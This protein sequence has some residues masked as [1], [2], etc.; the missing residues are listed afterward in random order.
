MTRFSC[1]R[2]WAQ[3]KRIDFIN[4][5][6]VSAFM[7]KEVGAFEANSHLSR[8]LDEVEAGR[9]IRITRHGKRI[10]VSLRRCSRGGRK[11]Y[12][13]CSNIPVVGLVLKPVPA[14]AKLYRLAAGSLLAI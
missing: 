13:T 7:I 4:Q 14:M 5:F 3:S 12:H 8:L 1:A 9:T 6:N 11:I 10:T 2:I